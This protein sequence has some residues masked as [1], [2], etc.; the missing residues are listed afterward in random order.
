MGQ[1]ERN[2]LNKEETRFGERPFPDGTAG[3]CGNIRP[4]CCGI[5]ECRPDHSFGPFTREEYLIHFVL[6]GCG[7]FR[8]PEDRFR[9]EAGQMFLIYPGTETLYR[10]DHIRPWSYCWIGFSGEDAGMLMKQIGFTRE[11]PV[12]QM[13]SG[14]EI[15]Q[16]IRRLLLLDSDGLSDRFLVSAGFNEIMGILL[17]DA[18]QVI[19]TES[20]GQPEL[21]YTGYAVVYLQRHFSEKIRIADLAAHIGVSRSYLTQLFRAH[22]GVSPQEYLIRIRMNHASLCLRHTEDSVRDIAAESGYEDPLAFSK[23]FKQRFGVS[24]TEYR[25][26]GENGRDSGGVNGMPA[27]TGRRGISGEGAVS[28]KGNEN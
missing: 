11:C 16:V 8:T 19:R 28:P 26:A 4:V 17:R 23:I 3:T 22:L 14:E 1:K 9:I 7:V 21:S 27:G 13:S 10:A 25:R 5:E 15:L 2:Y 6:D 18:E 24:P 12:L 20:A